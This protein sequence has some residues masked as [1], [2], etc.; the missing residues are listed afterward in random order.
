ME[1][2][3]CVYHGQ[4][5]ELISRGTGA[6]LYPQGDSAAIHVTMPEA[7]SKLYADDEARWSALMTSAQSGGEAD[8]RRLLSEPSVVIKRYLLS[9]IG[10]HDFVEDCVQ[11]SLMAIHRARHTYD[12]SR[13]FR[14]W[15]FAIVK[16]KAIDMLRSQRAS[17]SAVEAGQAGLDHVAEPLVDDASG[18]LLGCLTPEDRQA[19]TMTKLIGLTHAEAAGQ[20]SISE[21]AMKVR[22]HRAIQRLK[23]LMEADVA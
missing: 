18:Q 15:F 13:R 3:R 21:S 19:I 2:L 7:A 12:P 22:V 5:C 17:Q 4:T 23:R 8:Y 11:E 9:R 20:L 6:A 1:E 14:P 16:H 10:E